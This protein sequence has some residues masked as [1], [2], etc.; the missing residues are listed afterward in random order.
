[1]RSSSGLRMAIVLTKNYKP[2]PT[3]FDLRSVAETLQSEVAC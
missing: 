1:M 3:F 2:M